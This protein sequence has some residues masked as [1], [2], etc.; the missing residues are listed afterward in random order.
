[1]CG[2]FEIG[3]TS[4]I[5]CILPFVTGIISEA[6]QSLPCTYWRTIGTK[7]SWGHLFLFFHRLPQKPE[8]KLKLK[9]LGDESFFLYFLSFFVLE[10]STL[11]HSLYLDSET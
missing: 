2:A 10:K 3:R 6:S 11:R 8:L 5:P 7:L 4:I 9:W 1:M